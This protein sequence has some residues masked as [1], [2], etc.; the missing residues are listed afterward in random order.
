MKKKKISVILL[1][2]HSYPLSGK[3]LPHLSPFI[4]ILGRSSAI[5]VELV[6]FISPSSFFCL[7][8]LRL[9]SLGIHSIIQFVHPLTWS[10]WTW[11]A[12]FHFMFFVV[13]TRSSNFIF[14]LIH[15]ALSQSFSLKP[16]M[17]L[18]CALCADSIIYRSLNLHQLLL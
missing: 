5:F 7:P 15:I 14:S 6:E 4:M 12:Q 8:R 11:P 10:L 18:S 9:W 1:Y 2:R 3:G 16:R 13:S 17:V